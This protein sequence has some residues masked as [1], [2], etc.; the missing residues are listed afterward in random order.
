MTAYPQ[1]KDSRIDWLGKIPAGWEVKKLK[2]FASINPTKDPSRLADSPDE[3]AVFLPMEKVKED[4]T[5]V[6]D[7]KKPLK[8]LWNGFTYFQENDVI[9]AKITPCFENGKGALLK[10][11]GSEIGFGSTEFHVLREQAA[12]SA[13]QYLYYLTKTHQFRKMGEAFMTG[14]A[15][16]K[17]VPTNFLEDF[18]LGLPPLPEQCAIAAFLDHKTGQ[19]DS[20]VAKKQ[21]QIE[22]WQAYRA[23]LINQAVTKGLNPD[24]PIKDSGIEWLGKIPAGWEAKKLK[25][26]AQK[27]QTGITPPSNRLEYFENGIVDWFSPGDFGDSLVLKDSRRKITQKALVDNVA[28]IYKKH[29]VLLVGIGATLGKIGITEKESSSN[30]QINAITFNKSYNPYFGAYYLKSINNIIASLA[31]VATLAILNQTQTRNILMLVPPLEEQ[32]EIVNYINE[33][34]AR[35]DTLIAATQR[36]VERLQAYRASLISDAVTGKIDVRNYM[37]SA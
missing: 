3:L 22:R 17:R 29:S 24:A 2:H 13:S 12:L 7:I 11:L 30:Q 35:I 20:Y 32:I 31:N 15:G 37:D 10:D 18:A 23:A 19:I 5:F 25:Y 14:A 27:I 9:M 4:G 8:E 21:Q 26:V 33:Q 34:T 1:Y 6:S 36:Q 28:K 16:Q